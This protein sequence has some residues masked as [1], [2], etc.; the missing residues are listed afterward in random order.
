MIKRQDSASSVTPPAAPFLPS[1]ASKE[2]EHNGKDKYQRHG[3]I[4]ESTQRWMAR[5]GKVIIICASA[6][7]LSVFLIPPLKVILQLSPTTA[8]TTTQRISAITA[9][10]QQTPSVEI[11]PCP[12]SSWK[13][14]ENLQG[15]CPGDLK[16]YKDATTISQ[17]ASTCCT[18]DD[19]ISW[20]YRQ[21][22]GCIQGKDIRLGMEKDGP[23]AWCSD[24]PPHRWQG[25]HLKPHGEKQHLDA[26]DIRT[27][28]C[29]EQNWNPNEEIG[30]CFGLGDVKHHARGSAEECMTACCRDEKCGAWQWNKEL[31]CFYSKGMHSCQGSGDPIKFDPFV[32]RRKQLESRRYSDKHNKPWQ[33]TMA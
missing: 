1:A 20:Q 27:N 29:D 5:N 33:M 18:N 7:V 6:L 10:K 4:L 21:D 9:V 19:C 24:H 12:T 15:K 23:A 14:N 11:P 17:C 8:T 13:P 3:S 26:K 28:A 31:G 22:V 2:A 32:G 30:Q 25:Q 16:P